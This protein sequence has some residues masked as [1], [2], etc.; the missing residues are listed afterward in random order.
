MD[1]TEIREHIL[2]ADIVLPN[3]TTDEVLQN[4]EQGITDASGVGY[5]VQFEYG[6]EPPEWIG[7]LRQMGVCGKRE[8]LPLYLY[9]IPEESWSLETTLYAP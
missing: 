3:Y 4:M 5:V 2:S 7:L 6:F 9:T 1:F 8:G